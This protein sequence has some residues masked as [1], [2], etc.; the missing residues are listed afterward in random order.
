MWMNPPIVYE[1]TIP[2]AQRIN[3]ITAMVI[4]I[5]DILRIN[6]QQSSSNLYTLSH[7]KPS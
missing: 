7:M 6:E 4:S 2:R 3:R 5:E 1:V